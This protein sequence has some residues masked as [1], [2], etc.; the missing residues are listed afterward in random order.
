[1]PIAEEI[2]VEKKDKKEKAKVTGP[3]EEIESEEEDKE[4]GEKIESE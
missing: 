1:M 3:Y 4:E 2:K